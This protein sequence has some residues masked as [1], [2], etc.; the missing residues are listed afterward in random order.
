MR[1]HPLSAIYVRVFSMLSSSEVF[2]TPSL[3]KTCRVMYPPTPTP[4][5]RKSFVLL[6][7]SRRLP[8]CPSNE[9]CTNM[10]FSMECWVMILTEGK[11][12]ELGGEPVSMLL[13]YT[14]N[15]TRTVL[16][17]IEPRSVSD[18]LSHGRNVPL[19]Y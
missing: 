4:D 19:C 7:I 6:Q 1:P 14:I 5:I 17:G 12:K 16:P 8:A 11:S 2:R 10:K 3:K 18:C 15:P 13:L 9:S